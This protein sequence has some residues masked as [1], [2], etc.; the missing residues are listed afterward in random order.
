M[1]SNKLSELP[2]FLNTSLEDSNHKSTHANRKST[3]THHLV[4]NLWASRVIVFSVTF[5]IKTYVSPEAILQPHRWCCSN[6]RWYIRAWISRRIG[7]PICHPAGL[8]RASVWATVG[9]FI[10]T[11]TC[12]S[13]NCFTAHK[14]VYVFSREILL[15]LFTHGRIYTNLSPWTELL[16]SE[17]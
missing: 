10:S 6:T 14:E 9:C 15:V 7:S 2:G 13:S 11:K 8:D 16:L 12:R 17:W 5:W 1:T 3:L 4:I